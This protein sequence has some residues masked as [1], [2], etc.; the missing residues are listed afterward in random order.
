[1]ATEGFDRI[2]TLLSQL[3]TELQGKADVNEAQRIYVLPGTPWSY[4]ENSALALTDAEVQ[5]NPGGSLSLYV[6][7]IVVSTG[8]ATAFNVFFEEGANTVLGPYY[9]EATAGRGVAIAFDTPKKITAA[10]ALT[11]TTSAAIAH[12]IDVTGFTA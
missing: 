11:V 6:T 1:M 2:A 10:T 12:C 5:A 8:F 3:L 9:L 7:D 4:H